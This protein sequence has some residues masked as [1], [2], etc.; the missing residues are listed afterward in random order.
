MLLTCPVQTTEFL[1]AKGLGVE[2]H[3]GRDDV[4]PGWEQYIPFVGGVHLPYAKLNLAALDADLRNNSIQAIQDAMDT[5]S[6][7]GIPYMVM[8]TCGTESSEFQQV[9][10]YRNLID[11]IGT[12]ADY[13]AGKGITLCIENAALHQPKR[14]VYGIFAH[15]W[16][17][18]QQDV[19]CPNVL[20]ALDT[21]HAATSAAMLHYRPEDRF[22][23]L[24]EYLKHPERIGR[25]HWSDSRLSGGEAYF[26]D[27]HLVPGQGDLPRDFHRKILALEA[28]KTLE[29]RC[30]EAEL[31]PGLDFIQTL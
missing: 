19:A 10:S 1:S 11:S 7:Y 16:F 31:S 24:Y 30:S 15:E 29:Q 18:I 22:A 25:V 23:Y 21:S 26:G 9:G 6:R 20:L 27:L 14:R 13:A 12:L 8:H 2:V 28:V 3:I 4:R 17:Q 5:G